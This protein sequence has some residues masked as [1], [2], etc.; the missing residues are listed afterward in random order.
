MKFTKEQAIESLKRELTNNDRKTLRMSE[1]TL[2]KVVE[3]LLP[4]FTDD[5]T[6]LPDFI[7]DALEILNPVNDNIGNDKSA[8]IKQ[9][10]IEHPEKNPSEGETTPQNEVKSSPELEELRNEIAALKAANE[11]AAKESER[12]T[13]RK[14]LIDK[15]AEKGISDKEWTEMFMAEVDIDKVEDIEAKAE[16]ILKFY[17]KSKADVNPRAVPGAPSKGESDGEIPDS[18]A[19]AR[20]MAQDLNKLRGEQTKQ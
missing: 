1:K 13:K 12:A 20:K 11:K 6:G 17:N 10:N 5:E 15:I 2:N 9:W 3:A 8:F 7:K 19:R 18:I 16:S 4:K 14:S